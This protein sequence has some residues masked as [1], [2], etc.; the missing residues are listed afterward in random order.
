M[1]YRIFII[2]II[3]ILF[4]KYKNTELYKNYEHPFFN[5]IKNLP[6]RKNVLILSAGPSLNEIDDIKKHFTK[7]FLKNHS[8]IREIIKK[9]RLD[10]EKNNE[11][12]VKYLSNYKLKFLNID[13]IL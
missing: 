3:I 10:K 7:E 12:Q 4:L 6:R 2:L 11:I 9:F 5:D 8:N 1:F 13:L